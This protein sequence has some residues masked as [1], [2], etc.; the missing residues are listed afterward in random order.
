MLNGIGFAISEEVPVLSIV[1][2]FLPML[3]GPFVYNTGDYVKSKK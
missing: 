1:K 3:N 2:V